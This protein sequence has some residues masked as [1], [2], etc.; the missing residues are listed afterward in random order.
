MASR[1][2]YQNSDDVDAAA[3]QQ[4]QVCFFVQIDVQLPTTQ[5]RKRDMYYN[6]I[7][8]LKMFY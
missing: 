3:L 8:F 5:F 4:L 6:F 2:K 1:T 7:F